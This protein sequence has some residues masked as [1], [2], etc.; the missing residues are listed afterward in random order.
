MA[1]LNV[2]AAGHF[3]TVMELNQLPLKIAE[4]VLQFAGEKL[5]YGG[6]RFAVSI[7]N[8]GG[9][10]PSNLVTTDFHFA[11]I[12]GWLQPSKGDCIVLYVKELFQFGLVNSTLYEVIVVAKEPN[13]GPLWWFIL[14]VNSGLDFGITPVLVK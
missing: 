7:T 5:Q 9:S 14:R 4:E 13:M 2:S 3:L 1:T 8:P 11:V 10:P 6:F 12:T